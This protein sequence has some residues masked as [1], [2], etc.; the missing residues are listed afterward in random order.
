[1]SEQDNL[2]RVQEAYAAFGRGD[3]PTVLEGLAD[4]VEWINSG[5]ADIP[6]AGTKRGK[7]AVGEWFSLVGQEMDFQAFQARDLIAQG[8]KVVA[9]IHSEA[10]VRRTGRR[11]VT[12]LAHVFTFR[13]GKVLRFEEFSDTAALEAAYRGQ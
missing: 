1:M 13:D 6:I 4:D 2:K 7:Q 10:I 12:E 9:L 11:S 5:P 8:D 3:I